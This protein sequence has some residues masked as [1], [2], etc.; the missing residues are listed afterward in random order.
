MRLLQSS[1]ETDGYTIVWVN[2]GKARIQYIILIRFSL[3]ES[4]VIASLSEWLKL[5]ELKCHLE[6]S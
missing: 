5:N 4:S 3:S 1:V 6:L 2:D